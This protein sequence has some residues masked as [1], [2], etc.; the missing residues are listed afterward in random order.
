MQFVTFMQSSTGR[1]ARA[2]AGAAIIVGGIAI[3]GTGGI[4]LAVAGVLPLSAGVFRFCVLAPLFG[5]TFKGA[6]R[7]RA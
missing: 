1:L 4:I 3:G 6:R 7:A 5:A 2:L